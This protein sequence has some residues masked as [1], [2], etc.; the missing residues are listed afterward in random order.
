[1]RTT[2]T[3]AA[4]LAAA[5]LSALSV[6]PAAA[7][8]ELVAVLPEPD[9]VLETA[10]EEVEL[11]FTGEI[12]DIGH[13]VLVTDSEGRSVTDGPLEQAGTTVRQPLTATGA[14]DESYRVVW[15]VVSSDGHPVEGTFSYQVGDGSGEDPAAPAASASGEDPAAPAASASGSASAGN[16]ASDSASEG[17]ADGAAEDSAAPAAEAEDASAPVSGGV[18]LWVVAVGGGAASLAVLGAVVL[19]SRRRRR[20]G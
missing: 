16:G 1:M 20:D 17:A 4:L 12:M 5:A 18:P 10:P 14:G 11:S 19:A 8:D 9:S 3:T 13:Q 6:L 15:R 2:R 7:H